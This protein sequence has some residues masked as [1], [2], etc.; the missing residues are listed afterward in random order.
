MQYIPY[1]PV[2]KISN[3]KNHNCFIKK[4]FY[5]IQS[6]YEFVDL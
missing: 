3:I 2:H 4:T 1:S 5:N 6:K